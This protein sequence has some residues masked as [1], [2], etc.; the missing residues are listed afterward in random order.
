M[1]SIGAAAICRRR[2]WF[3]RVGKSASAIKWRGLG[4]VIAA[5][6]QLTHNTDAAYQVGYQILRPRYGSATLIHTNDVRGHAA[7]LALFDEVTG[8]ARDLARCQ[9]LRK[10]V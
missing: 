3:S 4:A 8:R 1:R 9:D 6:Y 2:E 5:A 10:T 7:V